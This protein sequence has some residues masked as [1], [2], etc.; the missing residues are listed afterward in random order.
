MIAGEHYSANA[1]SFTVA[2]LLLALA[3]LFTCSMIRVGGEPC[4]GASDASGL[5]AQR[6][7]S[8]AAEYEMGCTTDSEA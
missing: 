7:A 2:F 8:E 6:D 4:C 3:F 1:V 5:A